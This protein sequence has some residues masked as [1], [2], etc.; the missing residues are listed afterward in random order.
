MP[1]VY[2]AGVFETI[3]ITQQTT[4]NYNFAITVAVV[5]NLANGGG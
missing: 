3:S 5:P 2:S 1:A 4:P